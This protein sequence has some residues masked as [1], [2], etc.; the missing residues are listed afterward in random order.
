[1]DINFKDILERDRQWKCTGC[2]QF[3]QRDNVYCDKCQLFRPI[4]M[5]KNLLHQPEDSTKQEIWALGERRKIE[6]QLVLD[7]DLNS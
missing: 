1:L 2:Q 4:E 6:K 5:Y 7:M 3:L